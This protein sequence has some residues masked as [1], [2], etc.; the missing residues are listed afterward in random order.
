M[1]SLLDAANDP[2]IQEGTD[3]PGTT[4]E[5]IES[6]V[7][8]TDVGNGHIDPTD[9]QLRNDAAEVSASFS[10]WYCSSSFR[11][12]QKKENFFTNT[13]SG[14]SK[15]VSTARFALIFT[16]LGCLF[17]TCIKIE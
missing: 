7:L 1:F 8:P 6:L 17:I 13:I 2:V 10:N 4:D 15:G 11:N 9:P 16:C 12:Y 3:V 5:Y 14:I